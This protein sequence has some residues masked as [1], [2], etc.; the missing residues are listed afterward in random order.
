METNYPIEIIPAA[1]IGEAISSAPALIV[2]TTGNEEIAR[3]LGRMFS[4]SGKKIYYTRPGINRLSQTLEAALEYGIRCIVLSGERL[5]SIESIA[6]S[7]GLSASLVSPDNTS[8][9]S[10]SIINRVLKENRPVDFSHIAYQIY[11][12]NPALLRDLKEHEAEELRL[13]DL[14]RDISLTEPLLRNKE[15]IFI[16]MCSVRSSDYPDNPANSPNGLYAEEICQI[17]RYAGLGLKL[18]RVY[19]WGVPSKSKHHSHSTQLTAEVLWH[20]SEALAACKYEDP[21]NS[22]GEELFLRKIVSMGDDGQ[23]I[24]FINSSYSGRWWMEIPEI[25]TSANQY[26]PCSYSDY[27]TA[28]SG[29]VPIRWLFF[30]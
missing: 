22:S 17:A 23:D 19:L 24:V 10:S 15:Y 4:Q 28:C 1:A 9:G 16:D 25:K 18:K 3:T 26:V 21:G 30:F 7:G 6:S 11:K 12:C 2:D 5:P 13:G 27:L 20:I 29:E 8:E 14:R